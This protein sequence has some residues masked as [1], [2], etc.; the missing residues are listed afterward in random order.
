[1]PQVSSCFWR[2]TVVVIAQSVWE[3]P[4]T[5]DL[6]RDNFKQIDS[7]IFVIA[8]NPSLQTLQTFILNPYQVRIITFPWRA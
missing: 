4:Y 5:L 6:V 3:N 7:I 2:F 1:M 8:I